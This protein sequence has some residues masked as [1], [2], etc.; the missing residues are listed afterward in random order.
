MMAARTFDMEALINEVHDACLFHSV[1]AADS[2]TQSKE[3][4]LKHLEEQAINA[5]KVA[6]SNPTTATALRAT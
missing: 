3:N 6:V 1:P 4:R 2:S 5:L